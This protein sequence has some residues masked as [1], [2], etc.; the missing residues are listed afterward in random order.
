MNLYFL[1][2]QDSALAARDT[3]FLNSIRA[4]L[5]GRSGV[6]EAISPAEADAILIHEEFSF[7]EWRYIQKLLAA[8]VI[9]T[10]PHKTYTINTDDIAS[11][12]LRGI[13]TSLP[14]NR[15]D[16]AIH[17]AAPYMWYQN[18]L[19]L[20]R[21]TP[22]TTG[23]QFLATWR[24]NVSSNTKLRR[25]MIRACNCSTSML[26]EPTHSWF[27]QHTV[28]EKRRYIDV[29]R[30]GRFSLCPA[31]CAAVSWRI[32]ESMA[33]GI[34]P[35]IIADAFMPPR[36]P[37]WDSFSVRIPESSLH[38]LEAVLQHYSPEYKS[39]GALARSAW[40]E[41]FLPSRIASYY[42]D[43]LME[44]LC[45]RPQENSRG[46]ELRRWQS[47]RMQWSNSWTILQRALKRAAAQLARLRPET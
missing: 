9:G 30:N 33:L 7:K 37:D 16:P 41:F 35:V 47:F 43:A 26:A 32:Y 36:G 40:E 20:E 14:R 3:S 19:V 24:G 34:A 1:T 12:L 8:P 21:P 31:G 45:N 27:N 5:L 38:H 22:T 10:Y 6:S 44:L 18:E 17:R 15:F 46:A 4:E 25:S 39:M 42:C 23:P 2:P 28:E 29:V 11:G 13:Y